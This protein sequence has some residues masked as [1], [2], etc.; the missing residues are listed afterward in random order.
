MHSIKVFDAW[1]KV[2]VKTL[3]LQ[4]PLYHMQWD[5]SKS[6]LL[7]LANMYD[8]AYGRNVTLVKVNTDNGILE[9]ITNVRCPCCST[10]LTVFF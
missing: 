4:Y 3:P 10:H 2:M 9:Y 6:T 1:N 5:H 8:P 7:A